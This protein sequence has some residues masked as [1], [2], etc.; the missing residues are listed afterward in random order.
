MTTKLM[1]KTVY[2]KECNT[3]VANI[4]N[5]VLVI[6]ARHHGEK[7]ITRIQLDKKARPL[8]NQNR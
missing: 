5:G 3:P 4:D 1:K 7:H 6:E 8:D 2:C